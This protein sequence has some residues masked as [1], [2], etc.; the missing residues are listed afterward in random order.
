M[1]S[2]FDRHFQARFFEWLSLFCRR[3]GLSRRGLASF[4]SPR[5]EPVSHVLP[6]PGTLLTTGAGRISAL[7][8][9]VWLLLRLQRPFLAHCA[10][11]EIASLTFPLCP[12]LRQSCAR[13]QPH[14]RDHLVLPN[15]CATAAA[16]QN[17]VCDR[18]RRA[19]L[20]SNGVRKSTL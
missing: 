5:R 16:H 3:S 1:T 15:R 10:L 13:L 20:A 7:R 11:R 4:A 14:L 2:W 19:V 12:R 9:D 8:A 18:A 6:A 17:M